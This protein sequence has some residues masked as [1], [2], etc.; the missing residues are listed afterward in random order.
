MRVETRRV[1]TMIE[2]VSKVVDA[3]ATMPELRPV[4]RKLLMPVLDANSQEWE[5]GRARTRPSR[6]LDQQAT[7]RNTMTTDERPKRTVSAAQ[8]RHL[9]N[10]ARKRWAA[11]KRAG[12]TT[13][14]SN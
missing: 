12:K 1:V 10:A 5:K 13:W 9:R 7:L 6:G 2:Q 8:R 3:L 14:G 4:A 11:A